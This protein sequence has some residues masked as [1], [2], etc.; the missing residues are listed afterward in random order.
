MAEI[1]SINTSSLKGPKKPVKS[2]I[3]VENSGLKGDYHAGPGDKQVSLLALESYEIFAKT[4]ASKLCLKHGSFGENLTTIGIELHTLPVGT[5]LKVGE[6]IL[7][8]SKIG[9][10]CHAPCI[11]AKTA[12]KCIMPKEGIFAKVV[13]GGTISVGNTIS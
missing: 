11:I 8:V 7:G 12:G 10:E 5:K 3:L 13:T 4:G 1:V 2:A 6:C 9:K